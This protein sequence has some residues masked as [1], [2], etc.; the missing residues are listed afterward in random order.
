M[1]GRF[2]RLTA[3]HLKK[4]FDEVWRNA[5]EVGDG[6]IADQFGVDTLDIG[7]IEQD[8]Y[9][10]ALFADWDEAVRSMGLPPDIDT[11]RHYLLIRHYKLFGLRRDKDGYLVT[12]ENR[13]PPRLAPEEN[14]DIV[15]IV[16]RGMERVRQGEAIVGPIGR[17][18]P[19]VAPSAENVSPV[20]A[21]GYNS[22]E[23]NR[24]TFGGAIQSSIDP[25]YRPKRPDDVFGVPEESPSRLVLDEAE[26]GMISEL[27]TEGDP[28]RSRRSL[29][30]DVFG[31]P[32]GHA[33][34]PPGLSSSRPAL[35]QDTF[36][37]PETS[38]HRV[39]P[40]PD[41]LYRS[42]VAPDPTPTPHTYSLSIRPGETKTQVVE[43]PGLTL[44]LTITM[45]SM[46]PRPV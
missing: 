41:A 22:R 42:A 45:P 28:T 39:V 36:G 6:L 27:D 33:G 9:F 4:V 15:P 14:L 20:P 13:I 8:A 23:S 31:V 35:P 44:A 10:G 5:A 2:S 25:P 11:Y 16:V 1:T 30:S 21:D 37:M 40:D 43:L 12:S 26:K 24:E 19:I 7:G 38:I 3:E 34:G 46:L 32:D 18:E 17:L 29:P